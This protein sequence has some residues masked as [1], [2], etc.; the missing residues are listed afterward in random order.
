MILALVS[1]GRSDLAISA[2]TKLDRPASPVAATAS[3]VPEPPSVAA[4]S[5]AVP[6]TVMTFLASVDLDG[7]DRVAGVD[8]AGERVRALDRQDV[9]DLHHV[10]Q[11]G[12]ARRD[13]LAVAWSRARRTRRDAPIS[14]TISGA[15]FS[16]SACAIGRVVGDMHLADAGDLRGLGGDAV[17]ALA[18]DEQMDF[19]E[20]ATR[21]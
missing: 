20:L 14:S 1:S 12:D 9:A 21:R 15:T 17:D 16:A 8:R 10:E 4:L 18:G 3:I 6:R 19:A 13:V 7:R 11:R 5:K 2:P